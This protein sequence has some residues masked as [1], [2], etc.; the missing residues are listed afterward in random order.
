[1]D[2]AFF[3]VIFKNVNF[4]EYRKK[5]PIIKFFTQNYNKIIYRV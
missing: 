3:P 4:L 1:M 5:D 2:I